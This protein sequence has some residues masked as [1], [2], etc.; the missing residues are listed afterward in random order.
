MQVLLGSGNRLEKGL[1]GTGKTMIVA[2]PPALKM[3][4][5]LDLFCS[6]W[7]LIAVIASQIATS[8]TTRDKKHT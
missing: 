1:A 3:F 5:R 4:C 2:G 7:I 6:H 8:E